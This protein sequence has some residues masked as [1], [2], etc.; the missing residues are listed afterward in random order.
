MALPLKSGWSMLRTRACAIIPSV[1]M[2]DTGL[3]LV[4]ANFQPMTEPL[5]TSLH[6]PPGGAS[7]RIQ[8][9]VGTT[10]LYTIDFLPPDLHLT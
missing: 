9:H 6:A 8:V 4:Q 1:E 2:N 10:Y 5:H 3:P 7:I